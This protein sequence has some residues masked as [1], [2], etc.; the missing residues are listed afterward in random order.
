LDLFFVN[1]SFSLFFKKMKKMIFLLMMCFHGLSSWAQQL[2]GIVLEKKDGQSQALIGASVRWRDTQAGA[3]TDTEGRFKLA[4]KTGQMYLI[5]SML[6]YR[7]DTLHVMRDD[8]L[9]VILRPDNTALDEVSVRAGSTVLDRLNPIQTEIITTKA[10]AKAACCN[11]SES[12]ETNA[13][14]SVSY[15][16]AI[17]GAKQIQM[18]GLAG[19]Y[20]QIN[21]ENIPNIRGLNTTYGLSY[22]PGTWVSSID[23]SKGAGSVVNG[24]ESMTG[25]INVELRK[26]DLSEKWYVNSYVNSQGRGELNLHFA[27]K[28]NSR[29]STAVLSH[30]SF[31]QTNLDLNQDSFL[32]LPKYAQANV[33]N[34]WR[35]EDK[36]WMVQLGGKFLYENRLGGQVGF[37]P[38]T[39]RGRGRVYGFG[40]LTRRYEF[41]GKTA[42]LFPEKPYQGL[43]LIVNASQHESNAY[44]GSR[45]Y[46]GIQ[47]NIYTNL[48]YQNIL[49][50]TRHTYRT[51]ASFV[52]DNFQERFIDSTFSR[53]ELVPGFFA[54]YTYAY[55]EK[56]T[57]VLGG[58]VD[59][60]N[61][62]GTRFT[63]RAHVLAHLDEQMS[64]RLSAGKG[65]RVPN[66]IAENFGMLIGARHIQTREAIRPEE[67]W[68]YGLSLSREFWLNG[69]K[70]TL[71]LDG[72]RTDFNN[73]LILDMESADH[74]Y[75]YNLPGR[76]FANSWQAEVNYSPVK[77]M[78]LKLAYR[79]FDVR[80]DVRT[81]RGELVLLSKQFINQ[82]RLLINLGYATR[83]DKWKFDFT[84]QW[85][86]RRR[87]PDASEGH[88]HS[89][90]SPSV[91]APAFSNIN[92]QITRGFKHWELYVGGEN[93]NNF[94]QANPILSADNPFGPNFDAAMVWG[95]VIGRMVYMGM[96]WKMH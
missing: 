13:S 81:P 17:T 40:N 85:N 51:G 59:F 64:L 27:Q 4:R 54:E 52:V 87:I 6:G 34:R 71:V 50:D 8:F 83:F 9:T 80:N 36:H 60:H 55:P 26:P 94:T 30:G 1:N 79:Y 43:G 57:I 56:L 70:G 78:E 58:R 22:I 91:L 3:T 96:R 90:L 76:S 88:L 47:R 38:T 31:L 49:G 25:S 62:Y 32:D 84:W 72:Y 18:L 92:A 77:R 74:A 42:R 82:D 68:N 53:R 44:F 33:L 39:D 23:V 24:Y 66:G 41:F 46:T 11:L 67:S 28:L 5:V 86:G 2:S 16:D 14:V 48:I 15:T 19:N 20:V 29:W 21:T 95:P 73:Q 12:F 63:P 35:Y 45:N 65:W 75:F 89:V 61:L 7:S 69:Q 37:D 10:L 93:L